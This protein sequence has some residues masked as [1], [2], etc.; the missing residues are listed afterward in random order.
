MFQTVKQWASAFALLKNAE[1]LATAK[2]GILVSLTNGSFG[3][4]LAN[5]QVAIVEGALYQRCISVL[6]FTTPSVLTMYEKSGAKG[7]RHSWTSST[8]TISTISYL[9]VWCYQHTRK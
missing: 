3:F 6:I 7:A 4:A 5:D 8:T 2:I 1:S 9:A